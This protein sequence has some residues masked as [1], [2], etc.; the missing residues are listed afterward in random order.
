MLVS[1][2]MVNEEPLTELLGIV[3]AANIDLKGFT[4]GFYDTAGGDLSAVKRTIETLAADHKLV[5]VFEEYG[6]KTLL[7]KFAKLT[8]R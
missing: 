5:V 2:G 6:E 8:K 1:N 7:A 3:D 4:Q